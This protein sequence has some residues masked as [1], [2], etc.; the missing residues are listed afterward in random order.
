MT[1]IRKISKIGKIGKMSKI[2]KI[3]NISKIGKICS[4]NSIRVEHN[5]ISASLF[6]QTIFKAH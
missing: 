1:K 3:G 5:R 2:G 6:M 4:F